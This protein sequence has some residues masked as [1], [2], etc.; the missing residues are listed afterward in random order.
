MSFCLGLKCPDRKDGLSVATVMLWYF[1]V[2]EARLL[3]ADS[4]PRHSNVHPW[5]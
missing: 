5:T 1:E 3:D 2:C 4:E